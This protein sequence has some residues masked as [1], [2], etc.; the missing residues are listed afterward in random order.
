[1]R[2]HDPQGIDYVGE[3]VHDPAETRALQATTVQAR[4][5]FELEI[6]RAVQQAECVSLMFNRDRERDVEF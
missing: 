5:I 3:A 2:Y 1:M 4:Q 6:Y